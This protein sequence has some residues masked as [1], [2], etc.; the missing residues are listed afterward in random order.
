MKAKTVDEILQEQ[1]IVE[2][3]DEHLRTIS[4]RWDELE[5]L[6]TQAQNSGV[7][8]EREQITNWLSNVRKTS[9][10]ILGT[11]GASAFVDFCDR[12]AKE[13]NNK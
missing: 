1:H 4:L 11:A 3:R 13:I 9:Y 5:S 12:I 7:I 2:R 8:Y 10:S 6:M